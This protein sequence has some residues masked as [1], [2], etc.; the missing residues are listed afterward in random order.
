V[1]DDGCGDAY[2]VRPHRRWRPG[3]KGYGNGFELVDHKT[4]VEAAIEG[5][6]VRIVD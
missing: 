3:S 6:T 4:T 2:R 1:P 5:A